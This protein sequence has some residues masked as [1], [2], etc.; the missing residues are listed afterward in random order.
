LGLRY[1]RIIVMIIVKIINNNI[2]K[3]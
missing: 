1:N 2:D 3:I